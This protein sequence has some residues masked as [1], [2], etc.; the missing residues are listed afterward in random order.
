MGTTEMLAA[1][2]EEISRLN[3]VRD[4]LRGGE[5]GVPSPFVAKPRKKRT[6]SAEVRARV[7]AAQKKRWA[8]Q[9]AAKKAAYP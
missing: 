7:A 1:V 2:D 8:K 4:L 3:Q 9:K 5:G 6:L